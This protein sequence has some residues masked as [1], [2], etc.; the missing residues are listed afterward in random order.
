MNTNDPLIRD[1]IALRETHWFNPK[2]KDAAAGLADVGLTRVDIQ[3][4]ADRLKRFAPYLADAFPATRATGGIIESP[5]RAVPDMQAAMAGLQG[6][7]TGEVAGGGARIPGQL[8]AKLDS[9]LPISGSIK[10]RGGIY[11]VLELAERLALENE[12]ITLNSDYRVLRAPAARELFASHS[13]AVGST[14]NLGLSIGIM[15]AEL[16]FQATVHMS[17]DAR[18]WK[19][20]RLRAHGVTV[21]EYDSDYSVAVAAGRADAESDPR[22]HFVDD[23]NSTSLFLGYAV[24]GARTAAQ[25]RTFDVRI[26]DASPLIVYLPCG[27]GGG[28]GG[29]AFGL[30][31]ALGN[32]VRCI[33]AEPT[34]SPAMMLGVYTGLHD[35]VSVQNYGIDN[36][37]AADGLAVGRPSSFV[38]SR[39]QGL[40][41]GY[42]TVSDEN[43][44]RAVALLSESEGLL[45]E[46][47][48]ATALFGPG[49]VAGLMDDTGGCAGSESAANYRARLGLTDE[50]FQQATHLA[51]VTGGSMVPVDEMAE[52][53]ARGRELLG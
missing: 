3:D 28:P 35:Q 40:I 18:Q 10:A 16:G 29:V 52:Y 31:A 6:A 33:F 26:S 48:S 43:M 9:E 2:I 15:A 22:T 51:W 45:C 30:K 7:S 20:D 24:A 12:L 27:V 44:F 21:R 17:S 19:K 41:D 47:S 36:V 38:G 8:W 14:G 50:A 49:V 53:V 4:A 39:M 46:P 42:Y 34:H 32:A 23:E 5:I 11:E 13:V 25:L 37:T 1:L